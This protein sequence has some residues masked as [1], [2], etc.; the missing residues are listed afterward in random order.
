MSTKQKGALPPKYNIH[1]SPYQKVKSPFRKPKKA[2]YPDEFIHFNR[3]I[4]QRPFV[5][6]KPTTDAEVPSCL[7]AED[8]LDIYEQVTDTAAKTIQLAFRKYFRRH[9]QL[10]FDEDAEQ[11]VLSLSKM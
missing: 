9:P 1:S 4:K 8:A 3:K 10:V 11:A 2:P 6:T 5:I 7:D